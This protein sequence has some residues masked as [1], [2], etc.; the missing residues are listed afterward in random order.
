MES[1]NKGKKRTE[2]DTIILIL[3]IAFAILG[4]LTVLIFGD[5]LL[6]LLT[7]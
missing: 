7:K 6:A 5:Q 4:A 2:P 1:R 3:A